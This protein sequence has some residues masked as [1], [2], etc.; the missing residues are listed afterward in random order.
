[1][2]QATLLLMAVSMLGVLGVGG[3][4]FAFAGAGAEGKTKKRIESVAG[5]GGKAKGR[6][7]RDVVDN[8]A[9]R[10]KQ[11]QDTLKELEKKQ[12]EAKKSR[13]T[14]RGRIEQAGLEI[15]PRAFVIASGGS[16]V[17]FT[18]FGLITGQP[19]YIV[20]LMALAGGVGFPRWVLNF[21]KNRR[22]KQFIYEF[23]NAIDIIVRGVKAGLPLNDCLK[24]IAS[25]SP[26]PVGPEFGSL[27]EGQKVG[28]PLEQGLRRMYERMPLP[29]VNFFA[30]VLTIQQ[31]TGGNLSEALGNLALVLRDRKR[32]KGKIQAMS[33]EAKASAAII[34][35]LPFAV[36]M[37]VYLS[38]PQYIMLLFTEKFG[39]MLLLGSGTW[40]FIGILVMKKMINFKF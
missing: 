14:L 11:V 21:L 28:I 9:Q 15:E 5:S 18:L 35:S 8:T 20:A 17:G 19:I 39:N 25:E 2:D 38:S 1:M 31:K 30:I 10:R 16:A 12:E 6:G 4:V 36:M 24:V 23:A 29:E 7:L 26:E 32:M 13:L 37:L 3:V 40:M 33:S 22:Q 27:V 34:G